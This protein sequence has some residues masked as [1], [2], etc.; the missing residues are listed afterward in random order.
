MGSPCLHVPLGGV[1]KWQE[2]LGSLQLDSPHLGWAWDI[3]AK[4]RGEAVLPT[5]TK[6]LPEHS[7][8]Q[9]GEVPL[10]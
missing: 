8:E 4:M 10:G 2:E 7:W 1:G 6:P 5:D 9:L 3:H